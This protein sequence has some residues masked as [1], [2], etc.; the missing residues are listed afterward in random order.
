M[1]CIVDYNH[2]SEMCKYR[3][4][5]FSD[6]DVEHVCMSNV[7]NAICDIDNCPYAERMHDE[8]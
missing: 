5:R 2:L 1:M 4:V 7:T 3:T 6:T 8:D